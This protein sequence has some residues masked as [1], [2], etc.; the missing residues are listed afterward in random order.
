VSIFGFEVI[1][2]IIMVLVGGIIVISLAG[3]FYCVYK[4]RRRG[5]RGSGLHEE[6]F[7]IGF[8][9]EFMPAKKANTQEMK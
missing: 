7:D 1:I 9:D 3:F 2:K 8:F 5:R 6:R 4:C